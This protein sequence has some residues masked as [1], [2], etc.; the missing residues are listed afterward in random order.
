MIICPKC[1]KHSL[2]HDPD[3]IGNDTRFMCY[4]CNSKFKLVLITER[5]I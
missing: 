4:T 2:N 5:V 1:T 3:Y